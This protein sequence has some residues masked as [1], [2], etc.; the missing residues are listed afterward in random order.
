MKTSNSS[1]DE[2]KALH[3]QIADLQSSEAF[4][5]V[6][7]QNSSDIIIVVNI[8]AEIIYVNPAIER[9]LGYRPEELI[10]KSGFAYI[11]PADIPRAL[12]DFGKSLL[13]KETKIFNAFGIR[14]QD[15]STRILEGIGVNLLHHPVVKGFVMNVQD[16]TV[17]RQAE[18]E[19]AAY[20]QHLEEIVVKRTA[21]LSQIN[22]QL[23]NELSERKAAEKAL[24]ESQ[25][26]YRDFI[27]DAPIGV[28]MVDMSGKVLYVNKRIEDLM[29]WSR[30]QIVGRH[31]FGLDIFDDETRKCLLERF[32]A[33]AKG[34]PPQHLEIRIV[35]KGHP[36]LWVEV[37]TTI[38]RKDDV[39][40]GAQVVF[41]DT[42]ERKA[43]TE[44][45]RISEDRFR[46]L[47]Q[48]SSD[49]ISILDA[50]GRSVYN[51]PSAEAIFGYPLETFSGKSFL[52]FIHPDDRD[53][54][55]GR[56]TGLINGTNPGTATE[57]RGLKG[58]GTWRTFEATGKNLLDYEGINGV[59][60]ITR[61]ITE[62][63][64][65]EEERK[66]LLERLHR[67]ERIE[68]LGTLAGGVAHDLNNVL[69][70]LVGY[71]QLMLAKMGQD[72][73]LK[74]YLHNI[75]KSSEKGSAIIQDLL[76][77][78]R[79][80]VNMPTEVIN[81][82]DVLADFFQTPEFD[83]IQ[84]YHARVTFNKDLADD[85][86]NMKGLPVHLGKTVMNLISNAAEAIVNQGEVSITTANGYLDKP[87]PGHDDVRKGDYVTLTVRDN[88]LGISGA[89]RSKIFEP[90]YT[91][92][93]MG[94]SGTGLGLA[95]VWGTVKDHNGYI[96]VQSELGKGS[97]FT[98]YFPATRETVAG[99]LQK[100]ISPDSYMGSGESILI[101]DDLPEQREIAA[102]LLA[103]LGY[104]VKVVA[105]GEDA[106]DYMHHQTADVLVLDMLMEPGI[107][108]LETYKRILKM[109]PQQKAIITS[110]FSETDR[111]KQALE[112]GVSA[113]V[114][115][116]YLLENIGMALRKALTEPPQ[117]TQ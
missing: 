84:S 73:P 95:V 107:D 48:R 51:S 77:L 16:I 47:I 91:K 72:D 69:G 57:F 49:V 111:V 28:S 3:Q 85:L 1:G 79:R 30:E 52:G 67:V 9:Q 58:D 75:M 31:G 56:F 106:V 2:I 117:Q 98:I 90:F 21:E 105:S 112:L 93:V 113:Y 7:T 39:P 42:T 40:V 68:S 23:L 64:Q 78:A 10:G 29:G 59:A 11:V 88:G 54:I 80:G 61:D 103:K 37:I 102:S 43:A 53:N 50:E 14:H 20:R 32:A 87:L 104:R 38:L 19:L 46:T 24:K 109:H 22:T 100:N 89:D 36:A 99:N 115:K 71:T 4:F 6:I 108:G 114:R 60:F 25:E 35:R 63:K 55:R 26:K 83:R 65:A 44:A 81:L 12:L 86:R 74:K 34:D 70:A 17:R 41:V 13:T 27:E 33:R 76:T 96:D 15:G 92:K 110:G 18:A 116:P 5:R 94:R 66:T 82:N 62:R 97:T 101:V 8:K 45:L